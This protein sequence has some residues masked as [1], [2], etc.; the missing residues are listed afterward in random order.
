MNGFLIDPSAQTKEEVGSIYDI[1]YSR[2]YRFFGSLNY[3]SDFDLVEGSHFMDEKTF[4][5]YDI[6]IVYES[7]ENNFLVFQFIEK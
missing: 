2:G 7:V 5:K 1:A 6:K 3:L 4:N